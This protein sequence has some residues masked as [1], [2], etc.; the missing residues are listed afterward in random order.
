[1][2]YLYHTPLSSIISDNLTL[3]DKKQIIANHRHAHL[4]HFCQDNN[5][6]TPMYDTS[7]NGKPFI[8]NISNL[9]FNQSHCQ[10]DYALIYSLTVRNI[11]VDIENVNRKLNKNAL[12]RRYFHD[13]EYH[14]WQQSQDDKRWFVCWTIKEAVLKAHGLG[15]RLPLNEL[16]AVFMME[17]S[18]YVCHDKIG[19]FYF[20]NIWVGECVI[21]V[22]YPFEYGVVGIDMI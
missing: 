21:T 2:I 8:T 5:L 22:A 14:A 12:A 3:L 9:H 15:I 17:D 4:T 7:D 18:G 11:G 1:M 20:K 16:K 13:D 19:Q 6:P 10:T